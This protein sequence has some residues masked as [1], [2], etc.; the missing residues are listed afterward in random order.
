MLCGV[1]VIVIDIVILLEEAREQRNL[2]IAP[3]L[4]TREFD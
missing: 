3:L 4:P 1:I 2:Y